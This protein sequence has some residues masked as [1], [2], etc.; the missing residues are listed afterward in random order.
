MVDAQHNRPLM[1]DDFVKELTALVGG[2]ENIKYLCIVFDWHNRTPVRFNIEYY[3]NDGT[4]VRRLLERMTDGT[5][6]DAEI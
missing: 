4:V 3:K 5:V 6:R 2:I 1:P